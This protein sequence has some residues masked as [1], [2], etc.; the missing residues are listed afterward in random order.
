ML[1]SHEPPVTPFA[2]ELWRR[3]AVAP[4][5]AV[6]RGITLD[7]M[8]SRLA[9]LVHAAFD[10]D[11]PI[12]AA[13]PTRF[14][15]ALHALIGPSD[16][17]GLPGTDGVSIALP[18]RLDGATASTPALYRCLALQQAVRVVRGTARVDLHRE[19][20][21]TRSLY[22]LCEVAAVDAWLMQRFPGVAGALREL[23]ERTLAPCDARH[24]LGAAYRELLRAPHDTPPEC[25]AGCA[26]PHASL[27]RAR[28]LRAE[29][30]PG[31]R[32]LPPDAVLGELLPPHD[33]P[34]MRAIVSLRNAR[35][36]VDDATHAVVER[37]H[38]EAATD[39]TVRVAAGNTAPA[40][41]DHAPCAERERFHY[42]EWDE[43]R[44]AYTAPRVWVHLRPP[45][46]AACAPASPDAALAR[47]QRQIERLR[48]ARRPRGRQPEGP[49]PDLDALV[50][51]HADRRAGR[52]GTHRVYLARRPVPADV[53]VL[54]LVDHSNSTARAAPG[55]HRLLD[56]AKDAT[57]VLGN[58]LAA[59]RLP[60]HI[61]AFAGLGPYGVMLCP[62][63]RFDE[64]HGPRIAQRIAALEP[65]G[66]TRL[67][68]VVRHATALLAAHP[69]RRRL[70]LVLSD[71]RP[72]DI[73]EYDGPYG[74]ADS[75]RALHEARLQG[76]APYCLTVDTAAAECLSRLFGA[77]HHRLLP[78]TSALPGATLA[79]LRRV[80]RMR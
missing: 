51:R 28:A 12:R 55:G 20:R 73:D 71:G 66:C 30:F 14:A 32:S 61:A 24:P 45:V 56:V 67:G 16:A 38:D 80:A 31:G 60:F 36:E 22:L 7:A 75:A 62:V 46:E 15:G 41:A 65:D 77:G 40:R 58:A 48:D 5:R 33:H 3:N 70:L 21:T 42:P 10:R 68:A 27:H 37:V 47:V 19:L 43:Q 6:E 49:E 11:I 9:L 17:A 54:L 13:R 1:S 2:R 57:L 79:W 74:I 53:A 8:A 64:P 35:R 18:H 76:V 78:D 4:V 44:S 59:L 29:R 23:R 63:K 25:L 52:A 34:A 72:S 69:A 39:D 26:T 50:E